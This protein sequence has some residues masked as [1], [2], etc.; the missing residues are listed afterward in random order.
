VLQDSDQSH[1]ALQIK[2]LLPIMSSPFEKAAEPRGTELRILVNLTASATLAD[3]V[4]RQCFGLRLEHVL[5][6]IMDNQRACDLISG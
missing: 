3:A 5:R 1:H 6:A 2:I 4:L